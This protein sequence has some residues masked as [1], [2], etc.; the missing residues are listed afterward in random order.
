M[1]RREFEESNAKLEHEICQRLANQMKIKEIGEVGYL[2]TRT[3]MAAPK[4]GK[5]VKNIEMGAPKVGN[6]GAV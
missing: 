1:E 5:L 2:V 6:M 4:T 3:E